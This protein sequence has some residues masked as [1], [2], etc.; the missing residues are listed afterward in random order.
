ME[1]RVA[2]GVVELA[3]PNGALWITGGTLRVGEATYPDLPF[4]LEAIG[5]T[6][7]EL[8]GEEGELLIAGE[9]LALVPTGEQR[10]LERFDPKRAQT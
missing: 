6:R 10:F 9:G 4:A 2:H 7:L 3:P 8:R 5:P 1:I